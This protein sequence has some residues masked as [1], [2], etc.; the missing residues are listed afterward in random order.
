MTFSCDEVHGRALEDSP[1]AWQA[2]LPE[3]LV[4]QVAE[5]IAVPLL[6][7]ND[8][9]A[10]STVTDMTAAAADPEYRLAEPEYWVIRNTSYTFTDNACLLYTSPSPRD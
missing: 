10:A 5:N 1:L 2:G 6:L 9:Y 3:R 7:R 8:I 4:W